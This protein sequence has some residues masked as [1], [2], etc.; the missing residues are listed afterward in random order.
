M[1]KAYPTVSGLLFALIA[2]LQGTRAFQQWPVQVGDNAIPLWASWV[3]ALVAALMAIWA[4][5][6]CKPAA[7]PT[8]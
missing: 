2:I 4:F 3:A 5:C 6:S 1:S 7:K 8:A